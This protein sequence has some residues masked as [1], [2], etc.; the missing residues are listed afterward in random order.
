M[1]IERREGGWLLVRPDARVKG[2]RFARRP[3]NALLAILLRMLHE[4]PL[5]FR[6][7]SNSF[8]LVIL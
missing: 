8:A 4:V 7:I 3:F 6:M 1:S 2:A 5:A